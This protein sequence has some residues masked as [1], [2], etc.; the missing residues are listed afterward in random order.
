MQ[1][2]NG[3]DNMRKLLD[4]LKT[5]KFEMQAPREYSPPKAAVAVGTSEIE[6]PSRS[7]EEGSA[8]RISRPPSIKK[9]LSNPIKKVLSDDE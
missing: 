3:Q 6:V 7:I 5:L 2:I 1:Q 9:E 4:E 8:G